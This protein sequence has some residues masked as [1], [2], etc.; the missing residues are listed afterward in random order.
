MT[1]TA[2]AKTTR[3]DL[4]DRNEIR[5]ENQ[6]EHERT[7]CERVCMCANEPEP[8]QTNDSVNFVPVN[9]CWTSETRGREEQFAKRGQ[10]EEEKSEI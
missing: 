5:R 10:K 8:D 4:T 9:L 6:V 1:V 7:N 2:V 3:E